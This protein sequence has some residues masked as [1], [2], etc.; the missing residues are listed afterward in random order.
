MNRRGFLATLA[1]VAAYRPSW[2]VPA[3]AKLVYA[4]PNRVLTADYGEFDVIDTSRVDVW[5]EATFQ[6]RQEPR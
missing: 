3:T 6:W 4:N 1:A 2:S 5:D